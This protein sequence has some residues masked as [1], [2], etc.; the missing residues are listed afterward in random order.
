MSFNLYLDKEVPC[1]E[2]RLTHSIDL[3]QTPTE[4]TLECAKFFDQP[5]RVFDLYSLWLRTR[6]YSRWNQATEKEDIQIDIEMIEEHLDK[7]RQGLINGYEWS[8]I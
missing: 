5:W 7:V 4:F 8:Y 6:V 1:G 3:R 2:G